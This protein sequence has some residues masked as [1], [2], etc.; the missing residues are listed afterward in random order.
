[1]DGHHHRAA[2]DARAWRARRWAAGT[3]DGPQHQNRIYSLALYAGP[4]Y[5]TTPPQVKFINQINLPA[6]DA[7]S[8]EVRVEKVLPGGWAKKSTLADVLMGIRAQMASTGRK[9][10]QPPEGSTF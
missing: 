4:D 3:A 8:G 2:G 6:V 1:M 5:P 7:R 10:K 9:L